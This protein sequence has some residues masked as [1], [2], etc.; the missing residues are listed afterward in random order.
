MKQDTGGVV[1]TA[2]ASGKAALGYKSVARLLRQGGA[3]AVVLASNCPAG[4]REDIKRLAGLAGVAVHE[5][6]GHGK[7]LGAACKKPFAVASLAV[8]S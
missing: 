8:K 4:H 7:E 6:D 2:V 3:E 5:F 1:K